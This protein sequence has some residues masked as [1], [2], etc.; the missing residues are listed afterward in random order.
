MSEHFKAGPPE[1]FW[2]GVQQHMGYSDEEMEAYKKHPKKSNWALPM[3]SPE[4]QNATLVFEVV[5]SHGCA[6][7]MKPGDRLYFTGGGGVLDPKR[8]S[9]WCLNALAHMESFGYTVQNLMLHGIDP[10]DMYFDHFSCGDCGSKYGWGL[11]TMK[12]FVI[13]EDPEGMKA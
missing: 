9:P 4:I 11:V 8:S 7:G 1:E 13:K 6:V 2:K 10:N 3:A 5:E 12:A